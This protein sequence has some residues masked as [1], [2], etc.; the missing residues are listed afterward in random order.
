M[1]HSDE[2]AAQYSVRADAY[3]RLWG[4]VLHPMARRLLPG[5]PLRSARRVLDL[6]T[7][8]GALMP[9]LASAAPRARI[10][11]ADRAEGMLRVAL[12]ANS[13]AVALMD[14]QHLALRSEAFDV[15]VLAF[16]LFHVPDP[17]ACLVDVRRTLRSGGAV[18]LTTWAEDS[19]VPGL[20]TWTEELDAHGAQPDPRGASVM[21]HELMDTPDK[22]T[23]LLEAAGY[24]ST[25]VWTEAFEYRWTTG[26]LQAIHVGC[27]MPGRRLATLPE[28][29]RS[30]CRACVEERLA[31]LTDEELVYRPRVHYTVAER[32]RRSYSRGT[33]MPI[34]GGE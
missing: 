10:V 31:R 25:R 8:T 9:D 14:A 16:M 30:A 33:R 23:A 12:G 26:Q 17:K 2:L 27:G 7:G 1:N 6:G 3:S 5:L 21:Q 18:G 4:P 19:S 28:A 15:A 32:P 34:R 11:G 22:L 24:V 20:S 29:K 13:H